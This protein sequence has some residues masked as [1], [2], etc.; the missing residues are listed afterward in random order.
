MQDPAHSSM[1]YIRP[2]L[3][4]FGLRAK[5]YLSSLHT[6]FHAT[7][8]AVPKVDRVTLAFSS[9]ILLVLT[10]AYSF[11]ILP[12]KE[13]YRIRFHQPARPAK[14]TTGRGDSEEDIGQF[15]SRI[16]QSFQK[17]FKGSWWLPK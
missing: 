14:W 16:C 9:F 3:T 11:D 5:P 10:L 8:L 12:D 17:G 1:D 2:A 7:P 15:V 4:D 6:R 13:R